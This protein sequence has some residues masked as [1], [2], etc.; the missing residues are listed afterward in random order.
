VSTVQRSPVVQQQAP[1]PAGRR[2]LQTALLVAVGGSIVVMVGRDGSPVW[3]VVRV[4]IV[5]AVTATAVIAAR[6]LD[7]RGR[8][9]VSAGFGAAACA[10]GI[11]FSPWLAKQT[12]SLEALAALV[13]VAGGLALVVTG[14]IVRTRGRR[15]VRRAGAGLA[16]FVA[17]VVATF[18]VA[19]AV[20]STNVPPTNIDATPERIGL[21]Y[22][23]VTLTTDD[24]VH[25][26]GWYIPS[27]NGAGVVLRH[28]AGSTRSN[29]LAEAEVLARHGF[30]VLVVDARGHGDSGGR[31]M[32]FG[33]HGDAD[34]AAATS[35]LAARADVDR[36]RIAVVGSSMGGEEGIGASGSNELIQAVVAEG[37]TARTAADK[38]WLSDVHGWR[39]ALQELVERLQFALTDALTS[40]S[41]PTSLR[42]AVG[43]SVDTQYL[44]ITAGAVA[45]EADAA[46]YIATAAPDRVQTW[47]VQGASHTDGLTVA[48][49]EWETRVVTFLASVLDVR[50]EL[51]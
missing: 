51:R 13:A 32:D 34:I 12:A 24:G 48:P 46:A 33:W 9:W 25:L 16:T 1:S 39:G 40:A 44:L 7:D 21:A 10:L 26:A 19:P 45:D 27:T 4:A 35:F 49:E 36:D 28:G 18:V 3:Q 8:G 22:E 29:V 6:R 50:T 11:G 14:T 30:G 15:R 2:N 17:V 47:E 42:S 38:D 37:A 20:A 43:R 23:D 5:L 31:A 41:G